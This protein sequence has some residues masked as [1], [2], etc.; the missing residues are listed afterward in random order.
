MGRRF[1]VLVILVP[2]LGVLGLLA[3]T[4]LTGLEL[5]TTDAT[6]T[7][8][9][10][11]ES[12]TTEVTADGGAASASARAQDGGAATAVDA[13]APRPRETLRVVGT[14]WELMVPGI[15]ANG[16]TTPSTEGSFGEAGLDLHLK[17]TR[18]IDRIEAALAQGGDD[19][20]GAHIAILPLPAFV[21]SYERLRALEP[22]VFFVVAWSRGRDAIFGPDTDSLRSPPR[23]NVV[24]GGRPGTSE[25][26]T[27]LFML[28][29]AGVDLER[30]R[31]LSSNS[32]GKHFI[33]VDRAI[34][35]SAGNDGSR[36]LATTADASQLIPYV[37]IAPAGFLESDA[38]SV[39]AW[40]R[41]WLAGVTQMQSDVPGAART[42]AEID[43]APEPVALLRRVGQ[44]EFVD[45]NHNAR[46]LGLSGRGAVTLEAL[47]Q[48]TW[49]LWRGVSTLTTPAP[50]AVP[51]STGPVISLVLAG[52]S[53]SSSPRVAVEPNFDTDPIFDRTLRVD[54][55]ELVSELGLLAGVFERSTLEVGFRGSRA[56]AERII[57]QTCDR[58]DLP[59]SRFRPLRGEGR[60]ARIIL[61]AAP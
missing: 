58:Y 56:R 17:T 7:G 43:G 48:E 27:S 21:A 24:L 51:L 14:G 44:L 39:T 31:L 40:T 9:E 35:S 28:R 12:A 32:V 55:D 8:G 46:L 45:L 4:R 16:G 26:L 59:R 5:P 13:A 38:E 22:Q 10:S 1:I 37:A 29:H 23:R 20:E 2:L 11:T 60:G 42:V 25:T 61:H 3:G 41:A 15:L 52:Q 57:N 54:E 53:P 18:D 47:F 34:N 36:V 33:A 30:I 49:Q 50:A 6:E 19:D